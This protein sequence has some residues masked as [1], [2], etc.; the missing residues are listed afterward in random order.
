MKQKKPLGLLYYTAED[1][2]RNE[3][4]IGELCRYAESEGI[5]L[6]LCLASEPFP[7]H[8]RPDFVI[9]RSREKNISH[10]CEETLR[11]P[12]YNSSTVTTVTNDKYLCYAFLRENGLPAAGTVRVMPGDPLPDFAAPAVIKPP[13]GHGGAGVRYLPDA[14]AL[15]AACRE[16]ARPF[17]LQEPMC[18]GKDLRVYVMGGEIYAAVL[19]SSDS[20]FRSN[21]SL[22]GHA[23]VITPDETVRA[24]TARVQAVLPMDFAGVDFLRHPSGG[25]V[26]GEIEDAVGCRMLYALT[27]LNPA[28]D[29]IRL[30]AQKQK[31]CSA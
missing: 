13:D 12:V 6:R 4:F 8:L 9:N 27:E 1:V 28:R 21:F 18:P 2:S 14:Q 31:G 22:G 10:Y 20:D 19:R 30:I 29:Y 25:Y 24:L 26:I 11:I 23:E 5:I 15:D 16:T 3:W 7:A 17:L